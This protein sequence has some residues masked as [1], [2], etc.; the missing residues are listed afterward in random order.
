VDYSVL[1]GR[2]IIQQGLELDLTGQ[3]SIIGF[4]NHLIQGILQTNGHIIHI[5]SLQPKKGLG[6]LSMAVL[7][8]ILSA[9]KINEYC[10]LMF[11]TSR[12]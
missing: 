10:R 4:A 8:L 11:F 7:G 2:L 6:Y 12:V 5:V 9:K 3:M 1:K